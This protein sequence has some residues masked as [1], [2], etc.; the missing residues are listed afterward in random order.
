MALR[1]FWRKL[2]GR[3]AEDK[4]LDAR[5]PRDKLPGTD[6]FV[7]PPHPTGQDKPKY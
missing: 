1:D 7:Q 6:H 5:P 3:H 4:E 2:T